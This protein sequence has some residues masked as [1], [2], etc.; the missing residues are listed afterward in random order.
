[1]SLHVI[2]RFICFYTFFMKIKTTLFISILTLLLTIS[3]KN[4]QE[5][6]YLTKVDWSTAQNYYVENISKAIS[7][8]DSLKQEG[9][10]GDK[11]KFYFKK[12]RE[13]F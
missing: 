4:K 13:N 7:Y 9:F 2:W 8:L 1:M 6:E 12:V 3:C 5:K 10:K 11:T